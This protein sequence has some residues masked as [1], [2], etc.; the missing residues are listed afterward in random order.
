MSVTKSNNNMGGAYG[1]SKKKNQLI[2]SKNS[3]T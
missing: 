1:N 2:R 3:G